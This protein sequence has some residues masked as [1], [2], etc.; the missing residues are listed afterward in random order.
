MGT[1]LLLSGLKWHYCDLF[2]PASMTVR[3]QLVDRKAD[4]LYEHSSDWRCLPFSLCMP[5]FSMFQECSALT[6]ITIYLSPLKT[7]MLFL[8]ESNHEREA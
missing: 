1:A 6:N 2:S 8:P 3:Y 4:R 5:Y 7:T